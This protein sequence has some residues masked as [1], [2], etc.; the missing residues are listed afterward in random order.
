[1]VVGLSTGRSIDASHTGGCRSAAA[2][3]TSQTED[4]Q[5]TCQT[6]SSVFSDF[7]NRDCSARSWPPRVVHACT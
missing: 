2:S 5:G 1:M 7:G 6:D 4:T 3:R